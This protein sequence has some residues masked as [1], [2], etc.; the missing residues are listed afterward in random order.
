MAY[1]RFRRSLSVVPGLRLNLS[2]SGASLSL[3]PRGAKFTIGPK[4]SRATIGLPGS[5]FSL[6]RQLSRPSA[7]HER[8]EEVVASKPHPRRRI[9]LPLVVLA[10]AALV[11]GSGIERA[12]GWLI[13]AGLVLLLGAVGKLKT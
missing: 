3:G 2:K 4:G 8:P 11:L 6:T 7:S 9:M 1:L 13:A 10:I 5:G 12:N